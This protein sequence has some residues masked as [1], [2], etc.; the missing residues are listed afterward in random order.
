MTNWAFFVAGGL[1]SFEN[2]AGD[3]QVY[4]SGPS[5]P[6][7]ALVKNPLPREQKK[8]LLVTYKKGTTGGGQ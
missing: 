3:G 6:S 1:D 2:P 4:G 7:Q 5:S 8:V